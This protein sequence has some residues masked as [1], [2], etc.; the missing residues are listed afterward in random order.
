MASLE[1]IQLSD[2]QSDNDDVSSEDLLDNRFALL[3]M[4]S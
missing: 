4:R 1:P 2:G 3:A